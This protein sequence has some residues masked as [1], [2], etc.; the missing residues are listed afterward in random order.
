MDAEPLLASAIDDLNLGVAPA[1]AVSQAH[2]GP[3]RPPQS[4]DGALRTFHAMSAVHSFYDFAIYEACYALSD[5]C[6][7][8]VCSQHITAK[9]LSTVN[10]LDAKWEF[11]N[12][13]MAAAALQ[14]ICNTATL[15][16]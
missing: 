8:K 3:P 9:P 15:A 13:Y 7:I 4:H 16:N 14:P 12:F 6:N 1:T 11:L 5:T 2:I 10:G